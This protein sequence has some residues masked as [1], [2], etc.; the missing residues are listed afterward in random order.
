MTDRERLLHD[1]PETPLIEIVGLGRRP[2]GFRA[3]RLDGEDQAD[4]S[5]LMDLHSALRVR[6]GTRVYDETD[7]EIRVV[8]A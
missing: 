1:S 5:L 2:R 6:I 4:A 3:L 8:D 7:A